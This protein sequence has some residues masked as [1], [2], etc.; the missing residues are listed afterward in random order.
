M[1]A[2]TLRASSMAWG[3]SRSNVLVAGDE[4]V[5]IDF[6]R[7]TNWTQHTMADTLCSEVI[8]ILASGD[9]ATIDE[10]HQ[11]MMAHRMSIGGGAADPEAVKSIAA[12]LI[13]E[14]CTRK[15]ASVASGGDIEEVLEDMWA[16]AG[17]ERGGVLLYDIAVEVSS[18]PHLMKQIAD[19][20]KL[21]EEV[22]DDPVRAIERMLGQKYMTFC[23][24]CDGYWPKT[25]AAVTWYES[26][27][28]VKSGD[29]TRSFFSAC[30]ACLE[31][32]EVAEAAEGVAVSWVG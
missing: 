5:V 32:D 24:C 23:E 26:R 7:Y 17:G 3:L 6:D 14:K 28:T 18:R 25:R 16:A 31:K 27:I 1:L 8:E 22:F 19:D 9:R 15:F 10:L 13:A 21:Y 11:R 12:G 2:C 4:I 30:P 29:R 20:L